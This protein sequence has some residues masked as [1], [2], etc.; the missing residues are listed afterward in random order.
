MSLKMVSTKSELE[1]LIK[2]TNTLLVMFHHEGSMTSRT[3]FNTIKKVANTIDVA[4]VDVQKLNINSE[5]GVK[6]V[7]LVIGFSNGKETNRA[8]GIQSE[9]FYKELTSAKKSV[10]VKLYKTPTCPWCR[11]AKEHLDKKG[12]QYT[13]IDVSQDYAAASY[14]MQKSGQTGVPQ[15]EIG[16]EI[17]VGADLD[18]IDQL[19]RQYS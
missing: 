15:I 5:Y 19:L 6:A 16:N 1:N 13:E 12:V 10:E 11:V 4:V 9:N 7:P 2:S 3:A 8:I 14:L 18:R 17:V